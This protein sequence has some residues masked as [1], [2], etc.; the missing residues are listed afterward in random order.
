MEQQNRNSP[1]S[2]ANC[3]VNPMGSSLSWGQRSD[4]ATATSDVP[5]Q[6]LLIAFLEYE[7]LSCNKNHQYFVFD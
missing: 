5:V 1:G 7:C 6:L 2:E 4:T 3:S